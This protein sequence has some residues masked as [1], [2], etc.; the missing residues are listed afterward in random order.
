[1]RMRHFGMILL[2]VCILMLS[3]CHH[4]M[5]GN[6][7]TQYSQVESAKQVQEIIMV[8]VDSSTFLLEKAI[9]DFNA[10]QDDYFVKLVKYEYE[11]LDDM[12]DL[13]T[14]FYASL[15]QEDSP[16]LL[17][18]RQ[19]DEVALSKNGY[20]EDL[21]PWLESSTVL[22]KN[23]YETQVL[24]CGNICGIQAFLPKT[25]S[26]RFL[27]TPQNIY[28]GNGWTYRE[29]IRIWKN[30]PE[31]SEVTMGAC[32]DT[33]LSSNL[34]YFMDFDKAECYFNGEEF[35]ELLTWILER[36]SRTENS[37]NSEEE[38]R[39]EIQ[40]GKILWRSKRVL[41]IRDFQFIEEEFSGAA[42]YVGYPSP[43]GKPLVWLETMDN[44]GILKNST[45]KEGAWRFLEFYQK[46]RDEQG[47]FL[48]EL[49]G[50]KSLREQLF[51][52][53]LSETSETIGSND[54]DNK[55]YRGRYSTKREIEIFNDLL[56]KARKL[57]DCNDEI[58]DIFCQELPACLSGEKSVA[59]VTG[60]LQ[61]RVGLYL[62]E[63]Q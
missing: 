54:G 48:Y 26:L 30:H 34:S 10:S 3:G 12:E 1:M 52:E 50:D 32:I 45:H 56:S 19:L 17:Y 59:D 5:D 25:I 44:I 35:Q 27:V 46:H 39:E 4:G 24:E 41:S 14:R 51:Q 8:T 55:S 62:K 49:P 37:A 36:P 20:L 2:F 42:N 58:W 60:I 18:L 38:I 31:V 6:D 43:D 63:N 47:A 7:M 23:D 29:L 9:E 11:A 28:N 40:N 33:F 15:L 22:S 61:S 13:R 53:E 21:A 57:P 16:D